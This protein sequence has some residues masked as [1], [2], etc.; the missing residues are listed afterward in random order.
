MSESR[1]LLQHFLAGLAY[2][3]QKALRGAPESFGEFNAGGKVRTPHELVWHLTGL[4]GYA[5]TMFHGER[6]AP[7]RLDTFDAEIDRFHETLRALHDDFGNPELTAAITD[8]QFLHGPL[9]DAMTH[10][11]QLAMLRRLEG[12]PVPSENFIY[13]RISRDNLTR[14]QAEP[15]AP[16][17]EWT[18][19]LGHR[20]PG[21][22]RR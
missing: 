6:F 5:R 20:P 16:D 11:G 2:R 13:A 10:V 15:V 17:L 9:S 19:D 4:I 18:P 3:T 14:H 8:E 7:P 22:V 21:E 1:K 12:T